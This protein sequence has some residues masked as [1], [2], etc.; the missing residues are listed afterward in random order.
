MAD[1]A[2]KGCTLEASL[3]TGTGS[4][5]AEPLRVQNQA[6][7][8]NLVGDNGIYFDKITVVI[9]ETTT[10]TLNAQPE[11]A[12]S[13]TSVPLGTATTIDIDGT[14]SNI[15]NASDDTLAVQEGDSGSKTITFKFMNTS[16]PPSPTVEKAVK[17]TVK[18]KKAGQTS[19]SAT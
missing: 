7:D 14:A 15:L 2:V 6:S 5:T 17:V 3:D 9:P 1:L 18:V 8:K 11:G 12:S 10:V 4:I 16:S 19:V 13:P